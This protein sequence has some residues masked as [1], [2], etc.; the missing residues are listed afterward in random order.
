MQQLDGPVFSRQPLTDATMKRLS[1]NE[2]LARLSTKRWNRTSRRYPRAGRGTY[3]GTLYLT[4]TKS[5]SGGWCMTQQPSLSAARLKM[6]TPKMPSSSWTVLS[7]LPGQSIAA[8]D[9]DFDGLP[10][11]RTSLEISLDFTADCF[12]LKTSRS[13]SC[14]TQCEVLRAT[15]TNFDPLGF[16]APVLILAKLILQK[17]CQARYE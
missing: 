13:V 2:D 15:A 4:R 12:V 6:P 8:L 10:T 3:C 14:S 5:E 9:V 16:L 7:S 1:N 17:E 11:E